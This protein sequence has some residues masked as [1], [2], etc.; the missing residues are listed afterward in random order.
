MFKFYKNLQNLL[1]SNKKFVTDDGIILRDK[2]RDAARK[3]NAELL[4]LLLSDEKVATEVF[5]DVDG[6]KVFDATKFSWIINN[7]E[8]LPNSYTSFKNKIGL[9]DERG[10]FISQSGKVEIVFPYK[11]CVLEGGQTKD[12]QKR[13]EIFY[14][15]LLAKEEIDCLLAPKVFTN[16]KK[17]S[18]AGD[19]VCE[20]FSSQDNLIIKGNNLI[21]LASLQKNFQ[22]KIKCIYID[23]PY[24]TGSDSF[25]YNDRFNHSTWLTFMKNRLEIAKKLLKDDGSIWISIDDHEQ[26]YLK[27]LCDEIFGQKNFCADI[28]WNSTKSV[29]N[30]AL[31]SIA[32]THNLVYFKNMQYYIKNRNEFRL[33]EDESGF[34]NPDNDPRGAWK[35]DPFQV[36]GW[37]PNQQYEIVN[38]KTGK[39]YKPNPGNSWKNDYEHFKL[40]LAD[41]RIVFGKTGDSGPQRKRFLTE[42][43]ERGRVAKTWWD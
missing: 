4:H 22:N 21:A 23:V 10:E 34:S 5:K 27:V 6:V 30:T 32:H 20:K 16:A 36:G 42:A 29:T 17:I 8:F 14:H 39:I 15:E 1:K 26:A 40:L 38:P 24:N 19:E 25:G 11:D 33:L 28:L 18:A 9:V 43:V 37:R 7:Q 2:V 35:A 3:F 12:D 31:I 41:N 13:T